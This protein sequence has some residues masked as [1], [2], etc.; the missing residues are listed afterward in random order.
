MS[1]TTP[2]ARHAPT[3]PA[4][5][6]TAGV[7]AAPASITI[8]PWVDPVVDDTGVDPR[9]RY[10]E[11]FWLGVL[12]PTATWLLR[13]LVAGLDQDPDGY[14]LDLHTTARAMGHSYNAA[15]SSPFSK[16][17]QRCVMFGLAHPVDHGL[18]VR[19][20]IP[21]VTLR[22][23]QRMPEPL[24]AA[25]HE[26][27]RTTVDVDE[28]TRAHRLATAMLDL[29]DESTVIEH[30]LVALGVSDA[31]AAEVADNAVRLSQAS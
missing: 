10:V 19:R 4:L 8:V 30:H 31:V 7:E 6:P 9:S 14:D 11:M 5:D 24:Q 27:Q 29:G 13:R 22:H 21:Q 3:P 25:H 23:L 20:R 12:G 16:A 1:D 26:W 18:A 15:R 28:F 17:L 2:S